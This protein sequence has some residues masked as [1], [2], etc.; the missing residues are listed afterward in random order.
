MPGPNFALSIPDCELLALTMSTHATPMFT[1]TDSASRPAS[2]APNRA[3]PL[4]MQTHEK[5][6]P[7][8]ISSLEYALTKNVP[9][10]PLERTLTK[11]LDLKSPGM[12]TYK[13]EGGGQLD[14]SAKEFDSRGPQNKNS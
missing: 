9:A 2:S 3:G 8:R 5:C 13:K 14:P 1:L 4:E 6:R 10:T 11:S 12:N 7:G